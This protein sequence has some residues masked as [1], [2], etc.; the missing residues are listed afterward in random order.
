MARLM[1][2]LYINRPISDL[3]VYSLFRNMGI[4]NLIPANEYEEVTYYVISNTWRRFGVETDKVIRD[5]LPTILTT[6]I[7]HEIFTYKAPN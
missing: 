7:R 3:E 1:R 5:Y 6:E 2:M 4:G